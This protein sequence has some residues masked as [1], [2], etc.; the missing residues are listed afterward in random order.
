MTGIGLLFVLA[1]LLI[2][3]TQGS[4]ALVPITF[5]GMCCAVGVYN[6]RWAGCRSAIS[7]FEAEGSTCHHD[8]ALR[9]RGPG[10]G[11]RH[12]RRACAAITEK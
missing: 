2:L 11:R 9:R 1:G 12:P 8:R 7:F 10:P 3:P 6:W 5:F 4:K